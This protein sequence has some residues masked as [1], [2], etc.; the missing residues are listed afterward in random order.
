M[1]RVKRA[2]QTTPTTSP[3]PAPNPVTSPVATQLVALLDASCTAC[4]HHVVASDTVRMK[5][6]GVASTSWAC[7]K[8][9]AENVVKATIDYP[10]QALPPLPSLGPVAH[11]DA[12]VEPDTVT[13]SWGEEKF[14]PD[15]SDRYSSFVAGM[16]I[17][18]TPV[19]PGET[20][21]QAGERAYAAAKQIGEKNRRDKW[22]EYMSVLR[23]IRTGVKGS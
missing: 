8:C 20:V 23:E 13:V 19:R 6:I 12:T 14:F 21:V 15:P 2:V 17:V 3:A 18:K 16:V 11:M 22:Q 9:G 4:S 5:P 1:S 10:P 7:P